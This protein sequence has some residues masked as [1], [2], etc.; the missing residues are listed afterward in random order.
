MPLKK[1]RRRRHSAAG[2]DNRQR[3]LSVAEQVFAAYGYSGSTVGMIAE[4]ARLSKPNV[5][6]YFSSKSAIYESVLVSILGEWIEKMALFEQAGDEPAAKI[7]AYI[8]GKM[9]FSRARP[10]ASRVFANEIISGAHN[11]EQA[12]QKRLIP[13]LEKDVELVR[14]WIN[15]GAIDPI[16]PY[17]LFFLIWSSTQSYADFSAQI[18]MVL[19]K[20]QLDGED[21][22]AAENF[23]VNLILKGLGLCG[24]AR[25][26]SR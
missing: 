11:L 8:R 21:F 16:D 15:T 4:E 18:Q 3:I 26:E 12:I 13:Q 22:Q 19:R 23:L 10:N 5:L 20:K 25:S 1:N 24:E 14:S 9:A 6:Y 7:T 2:E 17:H